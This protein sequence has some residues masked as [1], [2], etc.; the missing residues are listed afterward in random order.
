SDRPGSLSKIAPEP[1]S[2]PVSVPLNASTPISN[3]SSREPHE[4]H[5]RNS[6][7]PVKCAEQPANP[8]AL[9]PN[10]SSPPAPNQ[11]KSATPGRNYEHSDPRRTNPTNNTRNS[12]PR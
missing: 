4:P 6:P 10:R 11:A 8:R 3:R 12:P 9:K 1:Q 2:T 7:K 5:A